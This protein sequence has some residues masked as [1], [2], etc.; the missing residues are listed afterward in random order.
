MKTT[1][2]SGVRAIP[3]ALALLVVLSWSLKGQT[4]TL[5]TLPEIDVYD[6]LSTNTRVSFQAKETREG[7]DPTQAEI[8]PSFEFYLRPLIKLQSATRFDLDDSK[9]RLTVI[10]IGYRYL[11]Q[12]NDVHAIN[13]IEPVM[14]FNLPIKASVTLS[15][16]NRADLDWQG[17]VFSWRYRN[18][19]QIEKT[20]K[21]RSYHARPY[22]SSEFF[23]E[24]Q[25]S[26]WSDTALYAGCLFPVR[27]H[28]QFDPY[29]E[30]QN[31]TSKTPNQQLNQLGLI[32]NFFF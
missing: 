13:R 14:T 5:Q 32:V 12:A 6:K 3:F 15:D 19:F 11:P 28:L 4:Q 20:L 18:R 24:S 16:K 9:S 1:M 22:A 29:Y 21:I 8:G 26:K 25:Y 30:H 27:K 10:S 7:S 23:Y 17:G 2:S 31:V